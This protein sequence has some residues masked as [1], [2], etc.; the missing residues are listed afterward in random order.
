[1]SYA[2][3]RRGNK[4]KKGVQ[5][6]L[7][8]VGAFSSTNFTPRFFSSHTFLL[9]GA[10]GTGKT[11]FI[12]TLCES[13]VLVHKVFDT[14][15]NAHAEAGIRI[16]PVNVGKCNYHAAHINATVLRYRHRRAGGG[17]CSHCFD[18]RRY[19]WI[20]RRHRQRIRVRSSNTA[21]FILM[22]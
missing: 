14:P 7:M 5:F 3:R 12:N 9:K 22:A 21:I 19:P 10:S 4:V 20:W 6:T 17:R 11:T 2:N 13:E 1:M 8:V 15:E 18:Y 16:K